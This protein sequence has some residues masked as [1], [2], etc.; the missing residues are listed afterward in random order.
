[1]GVVLGGRVAAGRM[2]K[3]M[4]VYP[5]RAKAGAPLPQPIEV[6]SM[7]RSSHK[8]VVFTG[9]RMS[10]YLDEATAR[11]EQVGMS[12]KG[13]RCE[14]I[15]AGDSLVAGSINPEGLPRIWSRPGPGLRGCPSWQ[16]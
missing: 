14:E 1:V 3:G 10:A 13:V 5:W 11:P 6:A 12:V 4:P 8:R 15:A 2:R 7:L 16:E 9:G